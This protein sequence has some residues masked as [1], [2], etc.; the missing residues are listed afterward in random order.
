MADAILIG[1]EPADFHTAAGRPQDARQDLHGGRLAGAVGPD[2]G[3][4]LAG[5]EA[6]R[7]VDQ[8]LDRPPLP[9]HEATQRPGEARRALGNTIGLGQRLDDDLRHARPAPCQQGLVKKGREPM[10]DVLRSQP[11]PAR[12]PSVATGVRNSVW[13]ALSLLLIAA[14]G[15]CTSNQTPDASHTP[16]EQ[17]LAV[18]KAVD[19]AVD[20]LKL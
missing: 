13:W 16:A 4:Q 7:D 5:L 15:G 19:H 3:Q 2:E 1:N 12:N 9:A 14:L 6:E 10:R 18:T 20:N 11:L 8:R 17:Q